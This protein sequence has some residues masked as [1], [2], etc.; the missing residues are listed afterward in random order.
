LGKEASI[1]RCQASAIVKA[2]LQV[3]DRLRFDKVEE[4]LR[5]GMVG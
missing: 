1:V 2:N 4:L 3:L 5:Y